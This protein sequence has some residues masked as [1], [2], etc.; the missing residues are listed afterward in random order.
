MSVIYHNNT[1]CIKQ[2]LLIQELTE[3]TLLNIWMIEYKGEHSFL[4]ITW[5]TLIA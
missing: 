5:D 2:G 3:L 4:N 1:P